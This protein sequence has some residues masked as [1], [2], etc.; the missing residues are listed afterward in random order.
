MIYKRPST[1][2]NTAFCGIIPPLMCRKRL[3]TAS[4]WKYGTPKA[5]NKQSKSIPN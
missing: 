2:R 3:K 4:F 1:Q 5:Q